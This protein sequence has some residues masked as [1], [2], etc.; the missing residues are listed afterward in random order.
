[1]A[2]V[3]K[4]SH[5]KYRR[6]SEFGLVYDHQ[7]YGYEDASLLTVDES[8]IDILETVERQP[9]DHERLV[10]QFSERIVSTM[11]DEGF[12]RHES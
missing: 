11:L 10:A 4:P 12:I 9:R 5:V 8:V 6:E 7:N 2:D 3:I 1:M